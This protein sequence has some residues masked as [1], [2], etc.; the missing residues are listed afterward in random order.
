MAIL[1]TNGGL[2]GD[3]LDDDEYERAEQRDPL[4]REETIANRT[5]SIEARSGD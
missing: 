3:G 5:A 4:W 2:Q 1:V